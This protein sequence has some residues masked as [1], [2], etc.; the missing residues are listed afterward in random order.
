MQKLIDALSKIMEPTKAKEAIELVT[1]HLKAEESSK[2]IVN[3][4]N[5]VLI[6]GYVT[7][8]NYNPEKK[9]LYYKLG[10]ISTSIK[11]LGKPF[12]MY[13]DCNFRNASAEE[14]SKR[15]H[16]GM[17]VETEAKL[18]GNPVTLDIQDLAKRGVKFVTY[19]DYRLIGVHLQG[20]K[21]VAVKF[22]D[23]GDTNG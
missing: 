11:K 19:T 18:R 5:R 10:H 9:N 2:V 16:E 22:N 15:I 4:K 23:K 21:Q 17:Y 12:P 7:Q 14:L 6:E 20:A 13:I 8:L 3:G 1:T